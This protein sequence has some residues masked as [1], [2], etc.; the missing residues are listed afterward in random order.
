MPSAAKMPGVAAKM[1]TTVADLRGETDHD[2]LTTHLMALWGAMGPR[3][4]KELLDY[5]LYLK[6]RPSSRAMERR[7]DIEDSD[8]ATG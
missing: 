3:I 7:E 8:A 6:T 1:G 5:G 2:E 4:R